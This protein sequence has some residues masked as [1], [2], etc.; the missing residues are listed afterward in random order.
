MTPKEAREYIA[1]AHHIFHCP[2]IEYVQTST[3]AILYTN[4]LTDEDAL[5]V[6]AMLQDMEREAG[7]PP[8][9]TVQ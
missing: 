9:A 5:R 6:A 1:R 8:C 3:G 4:A 2:P 7:R